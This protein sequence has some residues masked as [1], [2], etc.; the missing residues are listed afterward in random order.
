MPATRDAAFRTVTVERGGR[1]VR[2]DYNFDALAFSSGEAP[3]ALPAPTRDQKRRQIRSALFV[4]DPLPALEV[5]NYGQIEIAPGVI[6]ERVS[7]ATGYGLRVPAIVYR[8]AH[9]PAA[10]MPGH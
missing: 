9:K 3:Q 10:K 2:D 5:E 1:L 8:P 7:Y 4:P 6:A